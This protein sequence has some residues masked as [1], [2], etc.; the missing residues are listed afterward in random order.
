MDGKREGRISV[1][2]VDDERPFV[3]TSAKRLRRRGF[4]VLEAAS[5]P[6][7]LRLLGKEPVEV[8]VLDVGMPD[9]DGIQVLREIKMHFPRVQVIILTGHGD[10]SVAISG[11]AMGA[12]DYLM[13]PLELEVLVA[14]IRQAALRGRKEGEESGADVPPA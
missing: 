5:G 8:V 2:L 7:G 6:E 11:M 3:A 1:L 4:S 14:K 10:M 13:K 9:M 12:F